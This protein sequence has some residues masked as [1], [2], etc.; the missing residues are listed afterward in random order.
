[1]QIVLSA[2]EALAEGSFCG[3]ERLAAQIHSHHTEQNKPEPVVPFDAGPNG[4]LQ[5]S[6]L[7]ISTRFIN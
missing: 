1:M 6:L 4:L 2:T 5:L 3:A 7:C